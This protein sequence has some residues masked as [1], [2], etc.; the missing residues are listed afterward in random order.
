MKCINVL[1]YDMELLT[2]QLNKKEYSRPV[3]DKKVDMY[4]Y[5]RQLWLSE[6]Q[7]SHLYNVQVL[8]VRKHLRNAYKKGKLEE[9]K[10]TAI[11]RESINSEN[12]KRV[13]NLEAIKNIGHRINSQLV[14]KLEEWLESLKKKKSQIS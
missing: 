12:F 9:S 11:V 5:K 2:N 3:D 10:I 13:Y 7:I 1:K 6:K 14:L 8:T 4:F